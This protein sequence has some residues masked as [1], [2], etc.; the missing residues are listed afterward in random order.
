[1]NSEQDLLQKLVLS[2]K[3]MERHD[4]MGRGGVQVSNPSAPMV[5]DYQPVAASYNIPQEFMQEQRI[6]K[7][8]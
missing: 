4:N 2:K 1:M 7:S 3:I 5:E 8:V 6:Q